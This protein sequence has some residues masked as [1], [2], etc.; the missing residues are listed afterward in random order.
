[1]TPASIRDVTPDSSLALLDLIM[2]IAEFDR[3]AD[4]YYN[5]HKLNIAITGE[6]P[7]YFSEYKIIELNRILDCYKIDVSTIFDFG[8]GIGNSIPYF[9][10]HFSKATLTCG[11]VSLRSLE[12]SRSRFPEAENYLLIEGAGIPAEDGSFDVA[13]SACAFHHIPDT[14]H[15]FWL[16]ELYRITRPGGL[17]VIFEHNPFNPFTVHAVNTCPFDLNAKLIKARDLTRR[18]EDAGWDEASVRYH[19]FFPRA[20]AFLRFLELRLQWLPL[21][22]QYSASAR[23]V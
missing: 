10:R 6:A 17:I 22:A 18:V 3:F 20:L 4:Q 5:Q 23:K 11:D 21:G 14:E 19:L 7:E 8:S 1:L 16:R 12:L 9:R 15:V 2:A 13:F